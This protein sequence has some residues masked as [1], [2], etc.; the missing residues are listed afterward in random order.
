MELT[1][2][3]IARAAR[4]A[5]ERRIVRT[6]EAFPLDHEPL[7]CAFLALPTEDAR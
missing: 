6:P 1:Q 7:E 5:Q 4:E 2:E 3:S